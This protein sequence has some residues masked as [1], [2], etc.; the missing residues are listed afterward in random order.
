[1]NLPIVLTR[2]TEQA[3]ALA[4]RL[5]SSGYENVLFPL[6]EIAP[7]A[8]FSMLQHAM[9]EISRYA[10]VAFVSPN[11]V[12]AAFKSGF[13]QRAGEPDAPAVVWPAEVALAVVGEGSRAALAEY[14]ITADKYRIYCPTDPLRSDSETLLKELDLP[15]LA[16]C[17][18]LIIRA[19]TGRELLADALTAHGVRVTQVAAYRRMAPQLDSRM[20]QQLLQLLT[21]SRCWVI[22]SSE[23]LRTLVALTKQAGGDASVV[24][25]QRIN[26]MVSHVRIAETAQSLGFSC[27][28]LVGSGDENLLLALQS[29]SMND[30][31]NDTLN[32]IIPPIQPQGTIPVPPMASAT[33]ASAEK[34]ARAHFLENPLNLAI[35]TLAVLLVVQW[36]NTTS[37]ISQLREE[38]ARRLQVVDISTAESRSVSRLMQDSNKDLQVKIGVLESKQAESQNHELALQQLYQDLSKN[39]DDWALSEIEQVLSTASQQLQLAGNVQGALIAL[40]NADARLAHSDKPQFITIRRSIAHDMDKLKALP[41]LDLTGIALRLDSVIAQIERMPLWVDEKSVVVTNPVKVRDDDKTDSKVNNPVSGTW[42][43]TAKSSGK[44]D[45][46]STTAVSRTNAGAAWTEW[47]NEQWQSLSTEMWNELR[48]LLRIRNVQTPDALMLSPSQGYF[49]KENIKL[50]LLNARLALLSRNETA[51]RSDMI[52]AQDGITTY[53]DT[54]SRQTQSVQAILRQIQSSNVSIEMPNLEESLNA[55]RNFTVKR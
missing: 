40:Q 20:Q 35:G 10:M 29:V 33:T 17:E 3:T 4:Q 50:R 54:R 32:D 11:A 39:R 53:F 44:K 30:N 45:A 37:Q 36:W 43:G 13:V 8:E 6:L 18:V 2:P 25:L 23:A 47:L 9:S 24:D 46:A 7:L 34:P 51:F 38:L 52:A 22:S 5:T 12:H 31:P 42:S 19:E 28:R 26:L 27:V 14:G 21:H 15:S 1:M 48:Q 55:V 49:V 41:S 16:Q